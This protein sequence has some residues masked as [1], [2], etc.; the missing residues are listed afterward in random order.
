DQ[1]APRRRRQRG[2]EPLGERARLTLGCA[3]EHRELEPADLL[4]GSDRLVE[5]DAPGRGGLPSPPHHPVPPAPPGAPRGPPA[6]P[7]DAACSAGVSRRP[8]N[9]WSSVWAPAG[10]I[11]SPRT[12]LGR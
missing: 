11:D 12:T 10:A 1:Q 3:D 7:P 8:P 2:V 6:L 5:G 9:H 4:G